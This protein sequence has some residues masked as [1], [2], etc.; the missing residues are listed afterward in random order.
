MNVERE[1]PKNAS[2]YKNLMEEQEFFYIE[3]VKILDNKIELSL[4][5][6]EYYAI[7]HAL[8]TL[9][10]TRLSSR[11]FTNK[12]KTVRPK[13]KKKTMYL[14]RDLNLGDIVRSELLMDALDKAELN[15]EAL[16]KV[17]KK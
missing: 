1:L 10:N 5:C 14:L 17:E 15:L 13:N 4:S 2:K 6:K 7:Q 11:K 8:N 3:P 16:V 12:N 9:M